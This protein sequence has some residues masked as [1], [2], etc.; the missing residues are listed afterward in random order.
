[1]P[2][3]GGYMSYA[4][5]GSEAGTLEESSGDLLG[6]RIEDFVIAYISCPQDSGR[7][8]LGAILLT[9]HR[10]RPLEFAF[11]S[12]VKI[13][14]MQR[15]IHGRTLDE[16]ITVDL[17]A[18][19]LLT[20]ANKRPDVIFVDSDIL[21]EAHR[22]TKAPVAKLYRQESA[23]NQP[24]SLSLVKFTAAGG[25]EKESKVGSVLSTLEPFGDLVEPF[26]R[27]TEAIREALKAVPP[28]QVKT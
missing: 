2:S 15:I 18:K 16:A 7:N 27:M 20:E 17:I 10:T 22:L 1:M 8:Y 13:T 26:A 11:V 14:T 24:N 12:P 5:E 6:K 3:S 28:P 25:S 4:D 23:P 19:R 21:L 9:D